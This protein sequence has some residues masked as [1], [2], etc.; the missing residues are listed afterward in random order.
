MIGLD[1]NVL[2]RYIVQDDPAQSAR[3]NSLI[4]SLTAEAPGFVA[5][6]SV[7]ELLR[8]LQSCY[9]AR[10][11]TLVSVLDLLLDSR[12]LRIEQAEAVREALSR[13]RIG[14]ADFADCLIECCAAA[15][16]CTTVLTFDPLAAREAGMRAIDPG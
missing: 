16:G 7:V 10:H 13:F 14:Q 8:I 2:V 3:A 12:E 5:L 11:D 15:A 9:G 6:V 4:D 1:T